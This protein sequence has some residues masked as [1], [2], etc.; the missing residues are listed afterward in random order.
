MIILCTKFYFARFRIITS[1]RMYCD[2]VVYWLV[3][4]FVRLF[5][6]IIIISRFSKSKSP[7]FVKFGTDDQHLALLTSQ[8]TSHDSHTEDLPLVIAWPWFQVSSPN[9]A[10]LAQNMI[11]NEIQNGGGL[12][13]VSTLQFESASVSK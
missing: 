12:H 11:F 1:A 5:E 10:F 6:M 13:S 8:V 3:G 2:C 7:V 4:Q 9:L